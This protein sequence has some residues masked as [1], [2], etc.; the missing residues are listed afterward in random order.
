[1]TISRLN[2]PLHLQSAAWSS[3]LE[4]T[5]I[6]IQTGKY[7]GFLPHYYAQQWCDQDLLK[8]LL[9]EEVFID[10]EVSAVIHKKPQNLAMAQG[11]LSSLTDMIQ[12]ENGS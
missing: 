11:L 12:S 8:P 7:I 5:A 9:E 3:S 10:S 6:L 1:M 4:A 2:R